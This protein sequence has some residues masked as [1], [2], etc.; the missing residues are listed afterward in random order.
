M[1]RNLYTHI[2]D[3]TYRGYLIEYHPSE[4][5][6]KASYKMA[7]AGWIIEAFTKKEVKAEIR[8]FENNEFEAWN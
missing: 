8:A 2:K 1:E 6:T 4:G 7:C 5:S 3:F